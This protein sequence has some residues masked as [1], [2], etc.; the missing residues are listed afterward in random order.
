MIKIKKT[1]FRGVG[2][3]LVTPFNDG[4]ID[5]EGLKNLIEFQISSGVDALIIGGRYSSPPPS[6]NTNTAAGGSAARSL[7]PPSL[8]PAGPSSFCCDDRHSDG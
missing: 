1:V 7:L 2:T 8:P 3:A 4:K 6:A 5:Y